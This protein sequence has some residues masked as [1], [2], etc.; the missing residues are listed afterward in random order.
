[1]GKPSFVFSTAPALSTT[2]SPT[3]FHLRCWPS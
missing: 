2:L 1:V 3:N